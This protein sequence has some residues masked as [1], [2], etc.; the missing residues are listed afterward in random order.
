MSSVRYYCR[1]RPC[2]PDEAVGNSTYRPD[3]WS[4]TTYPTEDA[5]YRH[6]EVGHFLQRDD[7]RAPLPYTVT[8]RAWYESVA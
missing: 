6:L 2:I 5:Y 4:I 8:R 7:P 1:L 3:A